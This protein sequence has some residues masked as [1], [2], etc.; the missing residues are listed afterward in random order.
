[1]RGGK[2]GQI[3]SQSPLGYTTMF[4]NA[5]I[6]Q[7]QHRPILAFQGSSGLVISICVYPT[8]P[9]RSIKASF[10]VWLSLG[11]ITP[12][13]LTGRFTFHS[14]VS[15]PI[16]G[17]RVH[18]YIMSVS[19]CC[20]P[21]RFQ[22]KQPS[23]VGGHRTKTQKGFAQMINK[24]WKHFL[25]RSPLICQRSRDQ[26]RRDGNLYGWGERKFSNSLSSQTVGH[27]RFKH[28]LWAR[29]TPRF[30]DL[31]GYRWV[32]VIEWRKWVFHSSFSFSSSTM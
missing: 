21:K 20:S 19:G 8:A 7:A 13:L 31:S 16:F 11:L 17:F 28:A 27:N 6:L 10:K 29:H 30:G 25:T 12:L 14:A 32:T 9:V 4:H 22:W 24:P 5:L 1:M 23:G 26:R 15:I 3:F 18:V 2:N